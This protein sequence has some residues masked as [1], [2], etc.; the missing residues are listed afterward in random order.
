MQ[1]TPLVYP[2]LLKCQYSQIHW[3]NYPAIF[4][5]N[6]TISIKHRQ[7]GGQSVRFALHKWFSIIV[8]CTFAWRR[9]RWFQ[10]S[11]DSLKGSGSSDVCQVNVGPTRASRLDPSFDCRNAQFPLLTFK[12]R[13]QMPLPHNIAIAIYPGKCVPTV[14]FFLVH[15]ISRAILGSQMHWSKSVKSCDCDQRS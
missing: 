15:R 4:F 3:H 6:L 8:G 1:R 11:R 2:I 14:G 10:Q 5:P 7:I 9:I 13:I 12:I